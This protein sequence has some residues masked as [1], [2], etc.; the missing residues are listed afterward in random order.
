MIKPP[1]SLETYIF[2]AVNLFWQLENFGLPF[3]LFGVSFTLER[4]PFV[5]RRYDVVHEV[6]AKAEKAA[7]HLFWVSSPRSS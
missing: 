4:T 2:T 5:H 3:Q 6:A 1:N 7:P